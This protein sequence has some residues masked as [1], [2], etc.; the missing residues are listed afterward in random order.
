MGEKTKAVLPSGS[1]TFIPS[2][3]RETGLPGSVYKGFEPD[4]PL[5]AKFAQGGNAVPLSVGELIVRPAVKF[6]EEQ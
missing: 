4:G 3:F 6:M 2:A 5:Y 1:G